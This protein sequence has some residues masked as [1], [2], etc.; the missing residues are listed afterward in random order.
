MGYRGKT[1][2]Q[3]RARDLRSAGWTMPEIATELGVSRSSVSLW[4]RDVPYAPRRPR[5]RRDTGPNRLARE[6]MAEIEAMR[7]WGATTIGDLDERDLLIAGTALYAGG[8]LDPPNE[9][10][11]G[12]CER[13]IRERSDTSRRDGP[14]RR[15]AT[16][17]TLFR[18]GAIGSAGHC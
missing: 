17:R 4:T 6:R 7:A 1:A 2:E 9:A 5:A 18:G 13:P 15:A 11:D 8:R 14:R 12:V 3:G 16:L 10:P